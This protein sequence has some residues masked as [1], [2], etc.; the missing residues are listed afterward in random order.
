MNIIA[1][2]SYAWIRKEIETSEQRCST[3][4]PTYRDTPIGAEP[5]PENGTEKG[6]ITQ[7][8][9]EKKDPNRGDERPTTTRESSQKNLDQD[10]LYKGA[11]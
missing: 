7:T 3:P 8:T 9:E 1:A 4:T 10:G 6:P 5:N 2:T 11:T